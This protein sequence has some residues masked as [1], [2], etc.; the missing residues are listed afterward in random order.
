MD[1]HLGAL[2]SN[3]KDIHIIAHYRPIGL[4]NDIIRMLLLLALM[5][6]L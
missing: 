3:P 6:K 2:I 5:K 4:V 1:F